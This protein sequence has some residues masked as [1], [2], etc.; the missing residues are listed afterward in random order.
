MSTQP[1]GAARCNSRFVF[2]TQLLSVLKGFNRAA[3]STQGPEDIC[4]HD[5]VIYFVS[6]RLNHLD[7]NRASRVYSAI[8][9]NYLIEN[10]GESCTAIG[11]VIKRSFDPGQH[12]T[13]AVPSPVR[14]EDESH[15]VISRRQSLLTMAAAGTAGFAG[16][17][18]TRNQDGVGNSFATDVIVYSAASDPRTVSITITETDSDTPHTA[19]TLELSPGE[20]VDPVNSGKLPA[21]NNSYAIEVTVEDG[22]SETFEWTDP[23][24]ELA[25]LWVRIDES[26]NIK[27]LLQAG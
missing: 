18:S 24:A 8:N 6:Y 17:L 7:T 4:S 16:C 15:T 27:F 2:G 10:E 13:I 25:P 26:R 14:M 12:I 19:R 23:S 21:H 9:L 22:P 11:K 1:A 3:A 20:T 5:N